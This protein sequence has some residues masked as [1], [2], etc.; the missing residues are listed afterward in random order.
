L[1]DGGIDDLNWRASERRITREEFG[2]LMGELEERYRWLIDWYGTASSR[3]ALINAP[4]TD[5]VGKG[6]ASWQRAMLE[7]QRKLQERAHKKVAHPHQWIWTAPL[8]EQSSDQWTA[9]M[10]ADAVPEGVPCMPS[11]GREDDRETW[12]LSI[13][14][15]WP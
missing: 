15:R 11:P 6:L 9:E 1:P 7:E 5:L 8:L 12:W 10:V 4:W 3:G 14:I 13:W 2:S